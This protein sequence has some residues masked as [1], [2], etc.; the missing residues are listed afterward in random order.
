MQSKTA[1]GEITRKNASN[2]ESRILN[3]GIYLK[4]LH[5]AAIVEEGL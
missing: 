5:M 1:L 3:S 2:R 4:K